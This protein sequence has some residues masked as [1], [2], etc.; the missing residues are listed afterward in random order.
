MLLLGPSL[1]SQF[2]GAFV[3]GTAGPAPDTRALIAGAFAFFMLMLYLA[4]IPVY[5]A[6]I[7]ILTA[8]FA[9]G[10]R[11]RFF[12]LLNEAVKFWPRVAFLWIFVVVCYGL[13]IAFL[14]ASLTIM[15]SGVSILS[16]FLVLAVT[17]IVVWVIG[18]LWINFMF[19]QQ[20]A[21]LEGC[22]AFE[23]LRRSRKLARS[24]SDLPWFRRPLWR[25]VFIASAWFAIVV[26]LNWPFVS[27]F[28]RMIS[29]NAIWT[30]SDPQKLMETMVN[31]MKNSGAASA[32][33]AAGALQAI[34]K[35]LLGIAFVLLFLDSNLG[36][37]DANR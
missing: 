35:P 29:N 3:D 5:T 1:C 4:M 36:D 27:Q 7:Q 26:A 10:E 12:A 31:S 17:T 21:V 30:T 20:F 15:F 24:R 33:L 6:G 22:D 25:G 16:I 23:A 11:I 37:H 2:I 13:A 9:A 19:W 8:A 14:M 32:T 34:L 28:F 18:R